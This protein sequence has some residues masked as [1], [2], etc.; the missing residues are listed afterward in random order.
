[1]FRNGYSYR[2]A[3]Y[4]YT[5]W[6][7]KNQTQFELFDYQR[8]PRETRNHVEDPAYANIRKQLAREMRQ[9]PG[10]RKLHGQ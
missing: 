4:R 6:I 10:S 8:D 9:L 2:T 3:R 5:E 7:G 1:M